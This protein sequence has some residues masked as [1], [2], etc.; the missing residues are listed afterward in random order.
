ML[1]LCPMLYPTYYAKNYAGIM[2]TGLAQFLLKL[3]RV[4]LN[5]AIAAT[6]NL[7]AKTATS[8][9]L[10]YVVKGYN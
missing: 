10:Q 1:A 2:G 4:H 6:C 9:M 7:C 3:G 5:N 8:I